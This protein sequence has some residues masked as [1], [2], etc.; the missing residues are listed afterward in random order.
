MHEQ[1]LRD[2]F[3]NQSDCY[4]DTGRF[5]NDGSYTDGEVIQAIT[6]DKFIEILSLI[7]SLPVLNSWVKYEIGNIDTYPK[8]YDKY[9]ICRKDGKVHWE[10]WNGSGWAYNNNVIIY[11]AKIIKPKII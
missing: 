11:W 2:L 1:E 9:F 3:K 8:E 4:A 5:E 6:E 10:T 7:N